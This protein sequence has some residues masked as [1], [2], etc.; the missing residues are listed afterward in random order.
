ML[1]IWKNKN[2]NN[3]PLVK[4]EISIIAMIKDQYVNEV[5][6]ISVPKNSSI[7]ELMKK[8]KEQGMIKKEVY[9][10]VKKLRPPISLIINGENVTKFKKNKHPLAEGDTITIFTPLS[11]G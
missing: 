9:G 5:F 11:G 7:Q 10:F 2:N 4:V 6:S 3:H 1:Q 8:A